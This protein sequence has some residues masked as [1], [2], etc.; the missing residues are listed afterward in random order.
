M[1]Q[2]CPRYLRDPD[3]AI[4]VWLVLR[5]SQQDLSRP[6]LCDRNSELLSLTPLVVET[7]TNVLADSAFNLARILAGRMWSHAVT[8]FDVVIAAGRGRGEVG[9]FGAPGQ[10]YS[11]IRSGV[12]V[13]GFVLHLTE[14]FHC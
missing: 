7:A 4:V 3:G 12:Q 13:Q 9:T 1:I 5:G 6:R 10:R 11:G 14:S 8:L 2:W